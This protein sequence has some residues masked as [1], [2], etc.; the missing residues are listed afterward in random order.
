MNLSDVYDGEYVLIHDVDLYHDMHIA[1][2]RKEQMEL[3]EYLK[4]KF[5][6]DR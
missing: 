1:L 6:E 4:W 2:N 5:E 3:F